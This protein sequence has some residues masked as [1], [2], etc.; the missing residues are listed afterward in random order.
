MIGIRKKMNVLKSNFRMRF[1]KYPTL[2]LT[3]KSKGARMG[4]GRGKFSARVARFKKGE[5]LLE[6]TYLDRGVFGNW[7]KAFIKTLPVK[8][9]VVPFSTDAVLALKHMYSEGVRTFKREKKKGR[10]F[11][12]K[13][14]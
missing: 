13:L 7:Y 4:K 9:K 11:R 1:K 8:T 10:R 3:R 6:F 2:L 5:I 14:R 12:K